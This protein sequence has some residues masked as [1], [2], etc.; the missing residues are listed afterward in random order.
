M[1]TK[2]IIPPPSDPADEGDFEKLDAGA[3]KAELADIIAERLRASTVRL[4]GFWGAVA[5][6]KGGPVP[7][8]PGERRVARELL[9]AMGMIIADSEEFDAG[10][11]VHAGAEVL[12]NVPV[13]L[14]H[15][16]EDLPPVTP[17]WHLP[18]VKA[19][20]AW[21]NGHRG[22]GTWIGVLDTGIDAS[23][24]EFAAKRIANNANG[25]F[26]EF[27]RNGVRIS[28]A[29]R[30][31]GRHGTH[32]SGIAAGATVGVAPDA[33]LA[34]AAVLTYKL[35]G[36]SVGYFA[37]IAAGFNWL[38]S[39]PFAR[40]GNAVGVDIVNASLGVRGF[41]PFLYQSVRAA[42]RITGI[43]TV[44]CSGNDGRRGIG[45]HWSPGNYGNVVGVGATMQSGCV[46]PYSDWGVVPQQGVL[47][48][49]ICAPGDKV[50]SSVPGGGYG[51]MSGTSM[52]SPAV[53]GAC[54]LAVGAYPAALR[55]KPVAL[56]GKLWTLTRALP[57][58]PAC[59]APNGSGRG[60]L[61]LTSL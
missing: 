26:A 47:K 48:P 23:H 57:G 16:V 41:D 2:I 59:T 11:A 18:D 5:R 40:D 61:D 60:A 7:A 15:P 44:A 12:D 53:A 54:A 24:P 32:V 39:H 51:L 34:V 52:A 14:C 45:N 22:Q 55:R 42:R 27:D 1:A 8:G 19:S 17:S 3:I 43:Q 30:D 20:G 50:T 35:G 28:T 58:A 25:C 37:Q 10:A 36:R 56:C 4:E 31:A 13:D 9:P 6:G 21:A 38:A 49:D 46:A 29:A 33:E